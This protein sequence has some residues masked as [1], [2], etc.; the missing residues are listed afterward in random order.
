MGTVVD[1]VYRRATLADVPRIHALDPD[2]SYELTPDHSTLD[3]VVVLADDCMIAYGAVKVFA[4][5]VIATNKNVSAFTRAATIKSMMELA[6]QVCKGRPI[7]EL[8]TFTSDARYAEFLKDHIGFKDIPE[9]A[10][11]YSLR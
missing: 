8:F 3:T 2:R 5:L 1:K 7:D 4:E 9:K 11:S 6:V 10:L